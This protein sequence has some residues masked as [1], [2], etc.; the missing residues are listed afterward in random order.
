MSE[1]P[2]VSATYSRYHKLGFEIYA[3]SLDDNKA[4]WLAAMGKF[5]M[6]WIN[7]SGL[8]G[9]NSVAPQTYLITSIPSNFLIDCSTGKIIAKN[10]RGEALGEKLE[11]LLK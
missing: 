8:A 2:N 4:N 10:L 7:V 3:S 1:M 6:K 5:D 11:E 9:V